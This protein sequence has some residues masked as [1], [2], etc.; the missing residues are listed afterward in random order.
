[1]L[2]WA[3][4]G[5]AHRLMF[6]N[7][8]YFGGGSERIVCGFPRSGSSWL[9]ELLARYYGM[10]C[11]R[12]YCVP[13]FKRAVV[14]HTHMLP[15]LPKRTLFSIERDCEDVYISLFVKR[16]GLA[17]R[18]CHFLRSYGCPDPSASTD[19]SIWTEFLTW[20]DRRMREEGTFERRKA[21]ARARGDYLVAIGGLSGAIRF[22]TQ[23]LQSG[24]A[25][26]LLWDKVFGSSL[27]KRLAREWMK[28]AP[29]AS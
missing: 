9:S 26:A 1:M 16:F 19:E 18:I 13:S 12:H 22:G 29:A 4:R 24:H 15:R 11:P 20:V 7:A 28:R 2:K 17:A 10:E 6:L 23:L 27:P 25:T 3:S 14:I 8:V 21:W 5:V